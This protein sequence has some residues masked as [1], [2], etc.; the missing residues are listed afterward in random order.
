MKLNQINGITRNLK[1]EKQALESSSNEALID[2]K[3]RIE[4][5]KALSSQMKQESKNQ[6]LLNRNPNIQHSN[7]KKAI[8]VESLTEENEVIK[9]KI[10]SLVTENEK[11]KQNEMEKVKAADERSL[12][13]ELNE[14]IINNS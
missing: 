8:K 7:T 11:I 4:E 12:S 9:E 1:I 13:D 3:Y 14:S 6:E 10:Q 2:S 5:S